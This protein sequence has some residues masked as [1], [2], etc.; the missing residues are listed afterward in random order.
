MK[1]CRKL[2]RRLSDSRGFT[3]AEMLMVVLILLLVSS[4]VA[5]GI[6]AAVNAYQ[7]V[8][9]SANAQLLLST[10]VSSLRRELSLA[11]DVGVNDTE[12]KYY[13]NG[14]GQKQ[15]VSNAELLIEAKFTLT[16]EDDGIKRTW[17]VDSAEES[18][19][20]EAITLAGRGND[21]RMVPKFTSFTYQNGCFTVKELKIEKNGT[22]L[23]GPIDLK[24]QT[25]AIKEGA[26]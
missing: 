25:L 4:V 14:Q 2:R 19:V 1:A 12:V 8:V 22:A 17:V 10:T 24:I 11:S 9:D 13:I 7:K 23:A 18:I 20:P 3:L 16:S 21:V 6:P 26:S 5:T 15:K